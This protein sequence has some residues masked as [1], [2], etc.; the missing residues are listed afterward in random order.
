MTISIIVAVAENDAIGF[1]NHL[2]WHISEDL[3]RFKSLTTGHH[4]IMGRK[5]Y[6]SV[7]KPLPGRVNIVISR[8]EN[9]RVDGCLVANSFEEALELA[10]LD[11][12]VFI[13]GGGEIYKQALPITDKIYLTRVHAGFAGDTFFPELNLSEWTSESITK[14]KPANDDGLGYT[15]INLVRDR[16]S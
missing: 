3:K 5:T 8:Q 12:E 11:S 4:V 14:G 7:G 16:K 2:L 13:I 6:E 15:F 10:K 9:Y 1:D